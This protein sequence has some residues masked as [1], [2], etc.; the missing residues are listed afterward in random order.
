MAR[1]DQRWLA[2]NFPITAA[3]TNIAPLS[4]PPRLSP[5]LQHHRPPPMAAP[6]TK[7][8]PGPLADSSDSMAIDTDSSDNN[9]T[10]SPQ[11]RLAPAV[12][13]A[14]QA[15]DNDLDADGLDADAEGEDADGD[16]DYTAEAD[17]DLSNIAHRFRP[18]YGK[19]CTVVHGGRISSPKFGSFLQVGSVC[20]ISYILVSNFT[21]HISLLRLPV[22]SRTMA[23]LQTQMKIMARKKQ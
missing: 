22:M 6:V 9:S 14:Y 23:R 18:L 10:A 16:P 17:V 21:S 15:G 20:Q 11:P 12:A 2:L 5:S 13:H 4:L 3:H 19:V 7:P 8:L 1:G